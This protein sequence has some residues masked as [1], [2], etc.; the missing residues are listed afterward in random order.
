LKPVSPSVVFDAA[1][2]ALGGQIAHQPRQVIARQPVGADDL[3]SLQ[4][5][6]VL[7]VE[8][9]ELNQQVAL[10]LLGAVGVQVTVASNGE[11]GVRCVQESPYDLVL[12]DLQ[13]PVM[14]G[15][16]AT[17]QIRALPGFTRLPILAMTANA[18]AGDR[19]RSLEAGMNAH[20][21]KPIDPE[22][23]FDVL[24]RWLPHGPRLSPA[25]L[26]RPDAQKATGSMPPDGGDWLHNIAALDAA[27]GLRRVLGRQEAY[28][29][30]LRRFARTQASVI[31]DI[32]TALVEERHAD[33]ERAAHTLKGVAGSIGAR[34][35][36]GEAGAV[37]A[38]LRKGVGAAEL[39]PLLEP[40]ERTL[41]G[42]VSAL[43]AALPP[44][45]Q[46]TPPPPTAE[47]EALDAA[48]RRLEELLSQD[49]MEAIDV[50]AEAAPMLTAAFGERAGQI[51]TLVRD[52][53]FEDA[54]AAL[55]QA[56]NASPE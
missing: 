41:E 49:A 18:M 36:Q 54:L 27:D 34:Q 43:L 17:R 20:I 38:A 45:V 10:E 56:V 3:G 42:L 50:F 6:R 26:E 13:M 53:C 2:R 48:V 9:N 40:A 12:M 1:M 47:R 35:L 21:T 22:E 51:G 29:G 33:A 52:Y 46:V 7:L 14:D 8:D 30:L 4:G 39:D 5:A 31:R 15:L 16:E 23:L 25:A 19:E 28:V 55:R 44:E 24:L 32:R 11:Q 37:E